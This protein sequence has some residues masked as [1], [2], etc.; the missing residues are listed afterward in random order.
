[1]PYFLTSSADSIIAK[2]PLPITTSTD[3]ASTP[4]KIVNTKHSGQQSIS[5]RS[6]GKIFGTAGWD[7][8]IRVYSVKTMKE[9]A[10]LKW[11]REG[12]YAVAFGKVLEMEG[13][14][15]EGAVVTVEERRRERVR[16]VHWTA[17]GA[18]DGKVSLW[19]VY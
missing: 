1:M 12:C 11:H 6:D 13:G 10:V 4:I 15:E 9:L 7:T 8:R 5:I 17:G 2:H 18:K 19:N 14:R 16:T 3:A